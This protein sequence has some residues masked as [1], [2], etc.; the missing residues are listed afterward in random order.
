MKKLP[1]DAN[2]SPLKMYAGA[3]CDKCNLD[4]WFRVRERFQNEEIVAYVRYIG[5][6][7]AVTHGLLSPLCNPK[8]VSLKLP[9][10]KAGIG[11]AGEKPSEEDI[12]A[13]NKGV[14]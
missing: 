1:D 7:A 5:G 9:I 6:E 3:I 2:T 11:F 13:I 10:T 12:A 14:N 4:E 8:T